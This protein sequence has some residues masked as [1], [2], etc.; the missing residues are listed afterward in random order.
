MIW[1]ISISKKLH[2]Q[3]FYSVAKDTFFSYA[4][5]YSYRYYKVTNNLHQELSTVN[6]TATVISIYQNS[7]TK[8]ALLGSLYEDILTMHHVCCECMENEHVV[9]SS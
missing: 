4:E 3:G 5:A 9:L 6:D 1:P 8:Q 2:N 7:N